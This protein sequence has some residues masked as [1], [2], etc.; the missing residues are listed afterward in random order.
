[1]GSQS[2][3]AATSLTR[4]SVVDNPRTFVDILR[5]RAARH[6]ER[7]AFIFLA[8]DVRPETTWTYATLEQR[9]RAVAAYLQFRL[10]PGDR[11]V[12]C[13]PPGLEFLAGFFGCLF[14]GVIAVPVYPPRLNRSIDRL[15]GILSDARPRLVLSTSETLAQIPAAV[16]DADWLKNPS[17]VGTD[18]LPAGIEGEW[19]EPDLSGEQPALFQYTS[20]STGA[21]RGVVLTHG[22]LLAN[23]SHIGDC[24]GHH[25]GIS[26]N[27]GWLPVYHDMGLIGNVLHPVFIGMPLVQLSPLAVLQRPIRWLEAISRFGAHTSGGP[28]FAFDLCV[29]RIKPEQRERLDLSS[30]KVAYVGS[31][32]I[33]P[34]TLDDF[35]RYFEPCGFRRTAWLPCYGL[36]EAT[37]FVTGER[38]VTVLDVGSDTIEKGE[39]HSVG[40]ATGLRLVGSGR[41]ADGVTLHIVDPES[42]VVVPEG[43][44]GEIWVRGPQVANGYW[45][46]PE[47][48][49]ATFGARLADGGGPFLRTGDLGFRHDGQLFVT[50][51]IKDLIIIDGRNHY[52]QD[53]EWLVQQC[54]PA[55]RP[56][57]GA[58]FAIEGERIERL[59]IVQE[60]E[61]A[62]LR[63]NRKLIVA[64]IRR[65]VAEH[66]DVSSHDV[67]LVGPNVVPRTSSGKIQRSH[68][69]QLYLEG[70]LTPAFQTCLVGD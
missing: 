4:E 32:P 36:A 20:G 29:Q 19:K 50:G 59:V 41:P 21:P 42:R 60:L 45:N 16:A 48:T 66:H 53:I 56:N 55:L 31:E 51:R 44:I 62:G 15:Q 17:W 11:V 14:A 28:N 68:C 3:L 13:Y 30:W 23:Q 65:A 2:L 57:A 7:P 10:Q 61:R 6:P 26:A 12:L 43:R 70:K 63:E 22:N 8:D 47:E 64:A 40:A 54:H 25:E 67:V 49:E 5:Q 35:T 24:F 34:G 38:R 33:R 69:R 39:V 9:A 58:A 18:L 52:P 37:L 27:V 1:M 46:N